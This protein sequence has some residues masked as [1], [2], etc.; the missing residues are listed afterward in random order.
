MVESPSTNST[1]RSIV[2]NL[3]NSTTEEIIIE[4]SKIELLEAPD[5]YDSYNS[6][7]QIIIHIKSNSAVTIAKS[8][9]TSE[10]LSHYTFKVDSGANVTYLWK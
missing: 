10:F 9:Q 4:N 5:Y 6:S 7:G 3:S 1:Q 8:A 2:Y